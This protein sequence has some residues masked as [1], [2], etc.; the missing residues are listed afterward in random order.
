MKTRAHGN[1]LDSQDKVAKTDFIVAIFAVAMY[2]DTRD[3]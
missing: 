1:N 3:S 2:T